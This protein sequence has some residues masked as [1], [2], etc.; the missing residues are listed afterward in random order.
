MSPAF[1][2]ADDD[3]L[4][5][6]R[7]TLAAEGAPKV[8]AQRNKDGWTPLHQAAFAGSVE[9]VQL[10]IDSGADVASKC[11]DGDTPSHYA[12]AQGHLE[13]I[14]RLLKKGGVRLFALTDNDGES[15]LDV[16][17][18]PKFKRALEALEQQATNDE[19]DEIEE[20]DFD[21]EENS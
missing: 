11:S 7:Q 3:D 8:V 18:N 6:M 12:S 4:E 15:V 19:E 17:Q 21:D 14:K 10:L 1:A 5:L 9:V 2:A 13:V 20:V 16:A